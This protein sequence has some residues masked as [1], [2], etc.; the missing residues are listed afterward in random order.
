MEPQTRFCWSLAPLLPIPPKATLR[1]DV[2]L[3]KILD[4]IRYSLV[5]VTYQHFSSETSNSQLRQHPTRDAAVC[6]DAERPQSWAYAT[7]P[8]PRPRD[9]MYK[10]NVP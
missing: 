4:S 6:R 7:G 9:D 10:V 2:E 1:F 5:L 8:S 3:A